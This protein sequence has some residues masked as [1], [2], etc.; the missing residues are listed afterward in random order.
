MPRATKATPAKKAATK[1]ATPTKTV[2]R[3][4]GGAPATEKAAP[5]KKVVA[6]KAAPAPAKKVV[7]KKAP[8]PAKKA[9]VAAK[10]A[11]AAPPKPAPKKKFVLDKFVLEQQA[12]LLEERTRHVEQAQELRAEAD[13]MAAEME[14]GD[15]QF[16]EESGEGTTTAIDRERDLALSMQAQTEVEEVDHAL[17][18]ITAGTY[19][20][21]ERC[22]QQIPK[23]RLRAIPQARL[24][25]ACK[26]GGLSRR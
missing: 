12:L 6:K 25:I 23:A 15:V 22:G 24:C 3:R 9:P 11:P 13:Q 26:S 10:K 17:A 8:A 16:D 2:A 18:K 14:P 21:C 5:V 7:A 20:A 1:K 4:A 19:G